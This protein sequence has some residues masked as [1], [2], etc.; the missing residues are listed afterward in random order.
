LQKTSKFQYLH[1]HPI[2]LLL[3]NNNYFTTFS[4]K[5]RWFHLRNTESCQ[6][7]FNL[8]IVILELIYKV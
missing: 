7:S 4:K 2:I 1:I 8:I 6:N 3:W 5:D